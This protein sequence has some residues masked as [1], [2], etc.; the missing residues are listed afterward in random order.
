LQRAVRLERA[1]PGHP[2]AAAA[3]DFAART[4]FFAATS[5]SPLHTSRSI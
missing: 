1:A 5:S 2:T 3:K 4:C